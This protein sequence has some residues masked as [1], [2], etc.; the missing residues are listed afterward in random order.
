MLY[1]VTTAVERVYTPAVSAAYLR[2]SNPMLEN[3]APMLSLRRSASGISV[4]DV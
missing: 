3:Q 4:D 2:G 1:R